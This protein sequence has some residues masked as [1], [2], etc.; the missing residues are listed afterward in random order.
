MTTTA[1]TTTATT[2]TNENLRLGSWPD[3]SL[4]NYKTTKKKREGKTK[5]ILLF[6]VCV[7]VILGMFCYVGRHDNI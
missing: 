5:A 7:C 2:I 4:N 6:Y 1:T 3:F